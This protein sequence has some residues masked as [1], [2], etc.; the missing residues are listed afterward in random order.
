MNCYVIGCSLPT[1]CMRVNYMTGPV[2]TGH[3]GTNYTTSLYRSY[4]SV[5]TQYL[6]FV[7][8]IIKPIKFLLDAQNYIAIAYWYKTLLVMK[9]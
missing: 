7:T 9:V 6:Y 2:K 4:F 3:M 5:G 8:C 1:C